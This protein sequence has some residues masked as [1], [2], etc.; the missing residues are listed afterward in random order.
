MLLHHSIS[1]DRWFFFIIFDIFTYYLP[2][3]KLEKLRKMKIFVPNMPQIEC[4][5]FFSII[6]DIF[7]LL[8]SIQEVRIVE[9]NENFCTHYAAN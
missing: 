5:W 2:S 7:D 3:E 8:S 9:K 6:F 1:Q 4:Q